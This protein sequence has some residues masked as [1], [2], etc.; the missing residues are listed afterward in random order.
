MIGRCATILSLG[1]IKI[2]EKDSKVI[3]SVHGIENSMKISITMHKTIHRR[4]S[5]EQI[6]PRIIKLHY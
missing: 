1:T 2:M 6:E 3:N 4:I 5:N